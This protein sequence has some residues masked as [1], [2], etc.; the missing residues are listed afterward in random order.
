MH[1]RRK[2][3][4]L[5]GLEPPQH[6]KIFGK[7]LFLPAESHEKKGLS[8]PKVEKNVMSPPPQN[9]FRRPCVDGYVSV[10]YPSL[11]MLTKGKESLWYQVQQL[12]QHQSQ[13]SIP[14]IIKSI[15]RVNDSEVTT[16][17]V[18]FSMSSFKTILLIFHAT[19]SIDLHY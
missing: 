18:N 19:Y 8:P 3:G 15:F 14:T 2:R 9:S 13:P 7:Y 6:L 4:G 11:R 1:R 16:S 12:D 10:T 17:S 5:G